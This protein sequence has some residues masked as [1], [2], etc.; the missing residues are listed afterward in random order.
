[1]PIFD[2][3][4]VCVPSGWTLALNAEIVIVPLAPF[5]DWDSVMLFPPAKTK[6]TAE[7]DA[8][9]VVPEVFPMFDMPAD[10][11]HAFG[12]EMEIVAPPAAED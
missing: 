1:L 6:R 3:P 10:W 7:P 2:I 8:M 11:D 4:I 12:P 5:R 9:P